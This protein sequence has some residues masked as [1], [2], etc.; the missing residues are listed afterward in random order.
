MTV[1]NIT[2]VLM[3]IIKMI[4]NVSKVT[5]L[6]PQ[7]TKWSAGCLNKDWLRKE[8]KMDEIKVGDKVLIDFYGALKFNGIVTSIDGDV[9]KGEITPHLKEFRA[10][11]SIVFPIKEANNETE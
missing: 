8:D 11:K 10:P 2:W 9:I 4:M 7:P 3:D 5:A 6:L 1:Q